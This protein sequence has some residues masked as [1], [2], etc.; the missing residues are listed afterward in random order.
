MIYKEFEDERKNTPYIYSTREGR[1]E[2]RKKLREIKEKFKET[3]FLEYNV[4]NSGKKERCFELAWEFGHG[5]GYAEV[6]SY[7]EQLAELIR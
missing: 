1:L 6:E 7:F 2:Y 4:E 5:S 3:L